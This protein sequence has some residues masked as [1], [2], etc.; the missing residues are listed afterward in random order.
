MLVLS[1]AVSLGPSFGCFASYGVL[2]QAPTTQFPAGLPFRDLG[3]YTL[4]TC[5]AIEH[6]PTSLLVNNFEM[7]VAILIISCLAIIIYAYHANNA[8]KT[9][10]PEIRRLSQGWTREQILEASR[11]A[12]TAEEISRSRLSPKQKRRYIVVGGSGQLVD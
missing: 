8:L 3:G 6:Y 4:A 7:A 10:P 9:V 11:T 12:R 5:P 2:R 1:K